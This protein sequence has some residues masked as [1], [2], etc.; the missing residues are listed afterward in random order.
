MDCHYEDQQ[1]IIALAALRA[2]TKKFRFE[3]LDHPEFIYPSDKKDEVMYWI[4]QLKDAW[5]EVKEDPLFK[6]YRGHH[7]HKIWQEVYKKFLDV[8]MC[9]KRKK[10]HAFY[11]YHKTTNAHA[12]I[13][14]E[15]ICID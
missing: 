11:I 6:N 7:V 10:A 14:D 1:Q 5:K 13:L 9:K 3:F 8:F 4:G 15:I 12:E 2:K